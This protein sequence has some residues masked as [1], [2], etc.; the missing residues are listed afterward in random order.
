MPIYQSGYL[1]DSSPQT[2]GWLGFKP[3]PMRDEK[4]DMRRILFTAVVAITLFAQQPK[5]ASP[6]RHQKPVPAVTTPDPDE[7]WACK[8]GSYH[9]CKCP[10][11]VAEVVEAHIDH[12]KVDTKNQKDYE[13]CMNATPDECTIVQKP[14]SKHEDHTCKRS[15]TKARCRC[16]DG[17]AC[18]GPS[19]FEHGGTESGEWSN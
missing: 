15:C 2:A 3:G 7:H 8:L 16:H 18:F 5:S 4:T 13:A 12:C 1:V 10:A 14:D 19:L 6:R 9:N 17:P 11:M